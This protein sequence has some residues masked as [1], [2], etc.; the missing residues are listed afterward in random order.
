MFYNRIETNCTE[1]GKLIEITNFDYNKKNRNNE[2]HN[3]CSQECYHKFRSKYYVGKNSPMYHHEYT[4]EQIENL[5]VGIAKSMAKRNRNTSIQLLVNEMLESIKINYIR[6]YRIKYYSC[7]NYLQDYNL[8]IEV[9]G[10]YW[11]A[12]PNR[13]N[14][15][16]Y[17]INKIQEKTILKD[18]Q[19]L[20]Y[21]KSHNGIQILYLWE[22]DINKDYKKCVE[23]INL[24]IK[25]KGLL[26]DYNS[27][28][29]TY[30]SEILHLNEILIPSYQQQH[31]EDYRYLIKNK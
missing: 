9:M 2:N 27:Y 18:K 15:D 28:N 16:K 13:Y 3:F 7:D 5:S 22:S 12:N 30:D 11:H 1:C 24:Y 23:L 17:Y 10:D 20:G 19:K 21:I 8:I 31:A 4:K 6:E 25:N 29:Y 26:D 14:K